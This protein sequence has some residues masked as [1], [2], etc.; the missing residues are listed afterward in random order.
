[1][2]IRGEEVTV[3]ESDVSNAD[4]HSQQ[5][6]RSRFLQ[7]IE[8]FVKTAPESELWEI[9]RVVAAREASL[10]MNP[11]PVQNSPAGVFD[12]SLLGCY[13]HVMSW[14]LSFALIMPFAL[15]VAWFY[16][17]TKVQFRRAL[18]GELDATLGYNRLVELCP[19]QC[20]RLDLAIW[21]VAIGSGLLFSLLLANYLRKRLQNA[22]KKG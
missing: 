7:R 19:P 4:Q 3:T 10:G 16:Q 6:L 9:K 18:F 15:F 20:S 2:P 14:V 5:A 13:I 1:M 12:R 8:S 17:M 22:T 21:G 11:A